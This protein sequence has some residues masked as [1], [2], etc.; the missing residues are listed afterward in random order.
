MAA[1]YASERG[2]RID[3]L[4]LLAAYPAESITEAEFPVLSVYGSEDLVLNREKLAEGRGLMPE[5]YTELCI[6]G[7]NHAGFGSY[8]EQKGD[9]EAAVDGEEQRDQTVSA[10]LEWIRRNADE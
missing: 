4:I 3:G 6:Q 9:G 5:N 7:G 8:G 2:D 10:V 1:S